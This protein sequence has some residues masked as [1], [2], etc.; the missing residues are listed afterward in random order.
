MCSTVD[1]K[2]NI[3]RQYNLTIILQ[4]GFLSNKELKR[5]LTL[6]LKVIVFKI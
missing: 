1:D 5:E 6:Y 4:T 3:G 2:L